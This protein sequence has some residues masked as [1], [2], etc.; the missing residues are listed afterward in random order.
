MFE[1]ETTI[2]WPDGKVLL[3]FTS[4]QYHIVIFG[5]IGLAFLAGLAL[6]SSR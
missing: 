4:L 6:G 2:Y 5:I 1:G 3:R